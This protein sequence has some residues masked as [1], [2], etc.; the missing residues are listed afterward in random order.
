MKNS[1]KKLNYEDAARHRDQLHAITE[2]SRKQKKASQD[3][4][5][6][7]MILMSSETSF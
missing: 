7:D 5:D 1:S 2:F 6:R 3:F 4:K